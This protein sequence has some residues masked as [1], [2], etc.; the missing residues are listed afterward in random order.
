M[1]AHAIVAAVLAAC[2]P[3][4]KHP[5]SVAVL[6]DGEPP[7]LPAT[8]VPGLA[9]QP[10]ALAPEP[11]ALADTT[12]AALAS[13]RKAYASGAPDACRTE[14][15]K[16][17]VP[18]LL[19]AGKRDAAARALALDTACAF[20]GLAQDDAAR[21]AD[22]LAAFGLD[23]PA[24]A[25]AREAED[26]IVAAIA[27]A[28]AAPRAKL[29]VTGE[30]GARA[31]VDG[32]PAMCV[33][34]CPLDLAPGDHVIAVESDAHEPA[35]K[36]VRV[37]EVTTIA[38]AQQP[39]TAA[40]ASSQWRAR[41]GRGLPATDATGASL[42]SL[43]ARQSRVAYLHGGR[44]LTGSL[45]V[46]GKLRASGTGPDGPQLMREL[47]YDGGLLQRPKFYQRPWFWIAVTGL[48][49]AASGAIVYVTYEPEK[50]TMVSF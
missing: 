48:T 38:I 41:I 44:E 29:T 22:R 12:S 16:L 5:I 24:D 39:A 17:D 23:L 49:L 46:D 34:P 33:V 47:A 32:K 45:I 30:P 31:S 9:L 35:W 36:L 10:F 15:A 20:Q 8:S 21:A 27:K 26:L 42:L 40:R 25:V 43:A 18:A 28:S 7:A 2:A 14:I 1:H 6:V 37:P 50:Q 19:A 4:P 11:A 13:A 3:M